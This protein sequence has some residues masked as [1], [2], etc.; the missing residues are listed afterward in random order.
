M[1]DRPTAMRVADRQRALQSLQWDTPE[2]AR[3]L[4]RRFGLDYLIIDRELS[5]PLVHQSGALYIYRLR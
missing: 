2:G 3:A 4:A 1:Y 5:L